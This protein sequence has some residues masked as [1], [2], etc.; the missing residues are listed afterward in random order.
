ML[1][2]RGCDM[3]ERASCSSDCLFDSA[4]LW[5]IWRWSQSGDEKGRAAGFIVFSCIDVR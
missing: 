3:W 2:T 5:E 4:G 1:V